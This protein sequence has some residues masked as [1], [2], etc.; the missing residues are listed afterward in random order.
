[1]ATEKKTKPAEK[2]KAQVKVKDLKPKKDAKGG[3][4]AGTGGSGAG[5]RLS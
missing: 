5:I 4:V 1:M 2:A 3:S